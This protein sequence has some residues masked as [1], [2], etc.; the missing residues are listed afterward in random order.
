MVGLYTTSHVTVRQLIIQMITF[1]NI[2]VTE[3]I[4]VSMI[5]VRPRI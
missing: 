5:Q 4:Q 2:Q 1:S 3:Y